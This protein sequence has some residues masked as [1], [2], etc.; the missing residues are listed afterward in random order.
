MPLKMSVILMRHGKSSQDYLKGSLTDAYNTL[1]LMQLTTQ[2][3]DPIPSVKEAA[4][5]IKGSVQQQSSGAT[6]VSSFCREINIQLPYPPHHCSYCRFRGVQILSI[7]IDLLFVLKCLQLGRHNCRLLLYFGA[8]I[9]SS[10]EDSR[11]GLLN[12]HY[13][14]RRNVGDPVVDLIVFHYYISQNTNLRR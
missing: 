1:T 13:A 4:N 2:S 5:Q 11:R 6:Y 9:S 8:P 12:L 14:T 10:F 3:G 7:S